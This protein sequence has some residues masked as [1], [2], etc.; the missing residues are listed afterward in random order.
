MYVILQ[1]VML[2]SKLSF[3]QELKI[4]KMAVSGFFLFLYFN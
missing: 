4:E 3:G 1:Y 2:E